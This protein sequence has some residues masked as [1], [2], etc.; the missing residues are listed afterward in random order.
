[1]VHKQAHSAMKQKLKYVFD[2]CETYMGGLNYDS[3]EKEL[4]LFLAEAIKHVNW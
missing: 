1:M 2:N 3:F 4:K